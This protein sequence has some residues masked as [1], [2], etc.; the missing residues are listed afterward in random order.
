MTTHADPSLS[1]PSD[2]TFSQAERGD[3]AAVQKLCVYI[4][5]SAAVQSL[6]A[7]QL[8]GLNKALRSLDKALTHLQTEHFRLL[9]TG[10]GQTALQTPLGDLLSKAV[11][12]N[13][14]GAMQSLREALQEGTALSEHVANVMAELRSQLTDNDYQ[15]IAEMGLRY[16]GECAAKTLIRESA[17]EGKAVSLRILQQTLLQ[18]EKDLSPAQKFARHQAAMLIIDIDSAM[19]SDV[20]PALAKLSTQGKVSD[21]AALLRALAEQAAADEALEGAVQAFTQGLDAIPPKTSFDNY[22]ALRE[23]QRR[24]VRLIFNAA[25]ERQDRAAMTLLAPLVIKRARTKDVAVAA[26]ELLYEPALDGDQRSLKA[27]AETAGQ[28]LSGGDGESNGIAVK[29]LEAA[30]RGGQAEAVVSALLQEVNRR[31]KNDDERALEALGRAAKFLPKGHPLSKKARSS[32]RRAVNTM[33]PLRTR[34]HASALR[35]YAAVA[36]QLRD[37]DLQAL[38][39]HMGRQSAQ[40]LIQA[41]PHLSQ[42]RL[43]MVQEVLSLRQRSGVNARGAGEVLRIVEDL[44]PDQVLLPTPPKK[45]AS[46]KKTK[47]KTP[48]LAHELGGKSLAQLLKETEAADLNSAENPIEEPIDKDDPTHW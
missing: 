31:G 6:D 18:P 20:L 22:E 24:F 25:Q 10:L 28:A 13:K 16:V 11:R 15:G 33:H 36:D 27:L 23:V 4:A 5:A 40:V 39:D 42:Q 7:P 43:R 44:L 30:A 35:G 12:K 17:Q 46:S 26:G 32:L 34:G 14:T 1:R 45:G 8:S 21:R 48:S 9:L 2:G 41:A 3:A 47:R 37:R 38:L 19:T 29:I